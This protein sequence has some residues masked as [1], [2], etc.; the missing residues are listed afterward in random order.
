MLKGI[1]AFM[2][3]SVINTERV[4]LLV[5][6]VGCVDGRQVLAEALVQMVSGAFEPC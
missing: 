5:N 1:I 6:L 2:E 4:L 3:S